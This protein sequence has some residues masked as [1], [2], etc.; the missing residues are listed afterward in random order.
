[1]NISQSQPTWWLQM[2][3]SPVPSFLPSCLPACL[4]QLSL[5]RAQVSSY[6]PTLAA[7][8]DCSSLKP[9]GLWSLVLIYL[10]IGAEWCSCS[11]DA[12]LPK[13]SRPRGK[14]WEVSTGSTKSHPGVSTFPLILWA[15]LG[16]SG[17]QLSPSIH[18]SWKEISRHRHLN[19]FI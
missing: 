12:F 13:L 16:L 11:A 6:T 4:P 19:G 2:Q 10:W 1:M 18:H 7:W 17:Y 9:V 8:S 15:S 5:T 3:L 14:Q